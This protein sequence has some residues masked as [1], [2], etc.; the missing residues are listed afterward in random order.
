V[1]YF[2]PFLSRFAAML[3][4]LSCLRLLFWTYNYNQFPST[5]D[6]SE[7]CFYF[8][9]AFRFDLSTLCFVNAAYLLSE[10]FLF[11]FREKYWASW[12]K[13]MLFFLP[14]F[15]LLCIEL[16]D[17]VFF[18]FQARRMIF[19]DKSLLIN[20]LHLF[21][22]LLLR[23]WYLLIFGVSLIYFLW[24]IYDKLDFWRKPI[25][26]FA[27]W[28]TAI[29][30][31]LSLAIGT[32]LFIVGARGGWQLRPINNI[33]AAPYVKD[34][35][36]SSLL[37]NSTFS[38][39]TTSQRKG[40][41]EKNYFTD[42]Q[43][44]S[45]YSLAKKPILDAPF[46]PLNVVV[47]A[48]ES[49]GKEYSARYNESRGFMP[50]LDSLT[51]YSLTA[52]NT[53]ANGM[54]STYG[55]VA[56]TAGIPTMMDEPFMF[57]P[58][59]N[60]RLES[61]AT[62]LKKKNYTTSFFH[63]STPGSMGF[64]K[65]SKSAGYDIFEDMSNYPKN[66]DFDGNWGIFDEPYFQYFAQRLN[67]MPQPFHSFLFSLTS[68]EPYIV[69]PWFEQKY[70]NID[71]LHR[72]VLYSDNA[73]RHFFGAA[74]KMPWFENTLFVIAAD[75]TGHSEVERYQTASGRYKIPIIY[76]FPKGNLKGNLKKTTQQIDI[77]PS[78][79]DYLDYDLPYS[80]FGQSIFEQNDNTY[81]FMYAWERYH[82]MDDT[83]LLSENEG[84]ITGLYN[85]K[86]DLEV[87]NDLQTQFPAKT[88]EL[89]TA[90]QARIQRHHQ[91]MIHNKLY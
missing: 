86:K 80:A 49:F 85:Y 48:M 30:Q 90:L 53:F 64:D 42:N 81:V 6:W 33:S 12:S 10:I 38:I 56:M 66:K 75:H 72:S 51:E 20:S 84:K 13:K 15:F 79:M 88:Q 32:G 4:L 2:Y 63:G 83:Y 44:D 65:Y 37:L 70:P 21:P 59:Q 25:P 82:I 52:E 36:W 67:Q 41:T 89:W 14:N 11:P 27:W 35:R 71:P 62:L 39:L 34:T 74:A 78:I 28:K 19:S 8:I 26:F 58:Y 55:V 54:R 77:L 29:F 61:I 43:L 69:E 22:S 47:I 87:K 57:S 60:N 68:H 18:S 3:L 76:Y 9:A 45:L 24:R 40:V 46:R 17:T 5:W 73:L 91:A 23:Y 31:I 50:F 7:I 16:G 1:R